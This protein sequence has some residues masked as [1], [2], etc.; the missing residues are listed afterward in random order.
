M[1]R[2]WLLVNNL[3]T[4]PLKDPGDA[5]PVGDAWRPTLEEVVKA[6]AEGDYELSQRPP[7]VL[8]VSAKVAEQMRA[9][10]ADFGEEL[11]ELPKDAWA[12]AQCQWMRCTWFRRPCWLRAN[13]RR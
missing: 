1:T 7:C 10:V 6:L 5:H 13:C 12:A 8:P 2:C 4:K 11:I 9:Y 3:H